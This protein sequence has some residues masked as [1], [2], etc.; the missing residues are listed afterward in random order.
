MTTEKSQRH[1]GFVSLIGA[2]N[3][4]K[5]T[6]INQ[7]IGAK[8]SIVSKRVQTTRTRVLGI[9]AVDQTQII[10][11]DTP[12]IFTPKKRMERAMV[13]SAWTGAGDSDVIALLVDAARKKPD[14]DT[15]AI[16]DKL[17]ETGK[18]AVLIL[19]KIDASPKDRLLVFADTLFKTGVFTDVYMIS[20]LKGDGVEKF[21]ADMAQRMPPGPWHYAE[22]QMT[23]M[24]LRLLAAE[25][26]REKI[27]RNLYQ[28]LPYAVT[29]ETEEW[30]ELEN[31]HIEISQVIYVTRDSQKA[32]ILGKRGQQ[33]KALGTAA[34]KELQEILERPVHLRLF[35]KVREGWADDPERYRDWRLDFNA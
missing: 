21:L 34:R 2:P 6:L 4:G 26:T 32:I 20:A 15:L 25:I 18:K 23:D 28:E 31:G 12:G 11:I 33:I 22:D 8:V 29:V 24:P 19:N 7:L 14:P 13:S 9:R 10:F 3:A 1:C 27:F 30:N 16:V 17:K 5:S 35:V